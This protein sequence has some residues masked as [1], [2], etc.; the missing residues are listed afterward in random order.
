MSLAKELKSID[1][2][3]RANLNRRDNL[4]KH[5]RKHNANI[6]HYGHKIKKKQRLLAELEEKTYAAVAALTDDTEREQAILKKAKS[7]L[8]DA[9]RE[10][11]IRMEELGLDDIDNQPQHGP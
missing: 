1:D 4:A 7:L 2:V 9:Q 3:L 11:V 6:I 8:A 5:V 10:V